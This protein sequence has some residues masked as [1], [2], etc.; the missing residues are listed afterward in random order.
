MTLSQIMTAAWRIHRDRRGSF[1]SALK[2]AWVLSRG[3]S[4]CFEVSFEDGSRIV[5][6]ARSSDEARKAFFAAEHAG[7]KRGVKSLGGTAS[8][9]LKIFAPA[10]AV[11]AVQPVLKRAA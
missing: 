2:M 10:V 11:E 6:G 3:F 9:N 5:S 1:S 7:L 8:I 4:H